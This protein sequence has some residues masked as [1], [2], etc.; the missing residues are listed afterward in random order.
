MIKP[1][2]AC[3]TPGIVFTLPMMRLSAHPIPEDIFRT[4]S[5]WI[6]G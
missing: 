4:S 2:A 6:R 1:M 5:I 3:R